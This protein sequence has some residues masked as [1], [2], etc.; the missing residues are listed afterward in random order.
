MVDIVGGS[1]MEGQ[2]GVG[3]F[4]MQFSS[5]MSSIAT[6]SGSKSLLHRPLTPVS[7]TGVVT[8]LASSLEFSTNSYSASHPLLQLGLKRRPRGREERMAFAKAA[9]AAVDCLSSFSFSQF[10]VVVSQLG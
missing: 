6:E 4:I 2:K 9:I 10:R 3:F 5:H 1:R 7:D 8:H